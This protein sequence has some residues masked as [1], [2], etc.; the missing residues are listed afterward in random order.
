MSCI[1]E[2]Y[3]SKL[4]VIMY[5]IEVLKDGHIINCTCTKRTHTIS[6]KYCHFVNDII[7]HSVTGLIA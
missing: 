2:Y 5:C 1:E 6:T 3:Y 4:I 7:E